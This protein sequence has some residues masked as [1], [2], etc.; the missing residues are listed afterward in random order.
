MTDRLMSDYAQVLSR[1][2]ACRCFVER[3]VKRANQSYA[4]CVNASEVH[5]D[6][7]H[8]SELTSTEIENVEVSLDLR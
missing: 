4:R 1:L 5:L 8:G 2:P 3:L 7:S 6:L